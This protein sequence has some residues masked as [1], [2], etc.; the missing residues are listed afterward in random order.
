MSKGIGISINL[1]A[2]DKSK[3]I[4]GEKGTYANITVALN[5]EVNE[6]GKIASVWQS[7]TKEEV[8]SKTPKNYLGSGNIIWDKD[9]QSSPAQA[10]KAK[11]KAQEV[12]DDLPF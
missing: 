6:Y 1:S 2:L 3:L 4:K 11:A 5:D 8:S 7:Q 9:S 12:V 10:P